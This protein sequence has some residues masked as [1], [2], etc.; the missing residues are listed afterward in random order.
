M[1]I[2]RHSRLFYILF[3]C[4]CVGS[5]SVI[6]KVGVNQVHSSQA[7]FNAT[8]ASV[9]SLKTHKKKVKNKKILNIN[10]FFD[11]VYLVLGPDEVKKIV[12]VDSYLINLFI[13]FN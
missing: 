1:R 3:Y 5:S 9:D 10:L 12:Y 13:F 7:E 11:E 8:N 6:I 2:H 4:V